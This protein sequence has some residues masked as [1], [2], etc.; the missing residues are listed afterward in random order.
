MNPIRKL[1]VVLL[2][3]STLYLMARGGGKVVVLPTTASAASPANPAPPAPVT[4]AQ[5]VVTTIPATPAPPTEAAVPTS[6]GAD[7]VWVAGYYNWQGDH[8]QWTPGTWVQT[9]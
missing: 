8:Y 1:S 9:P 5:V 3:A 6:P 2:S 7:Y 4:P